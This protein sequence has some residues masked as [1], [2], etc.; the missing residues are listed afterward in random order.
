MSRRSLVVISAGMSQPSSTRLLA[1]QL[2]AAT[3]QRLSATGTSTDVTVIELRA[4]AH[5]ITNRLLA[6]FASPALQQALDAVAGADG[7]I[8][9]TP[10][11]SASYS[12]LFKSFFDVLDTDAVV[13]MPVLIAATGG[14][15]RHSLALEHALRPLFSYLRAAVMPTAVFAASSDWGS[16]RDADSSLA[17]R[18]DRAGGELSRAITSTAPR[19]SLDAYAGAPAFAELMGR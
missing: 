14:T 19:T 15:E 5:D 6:G 8:A 16:G 17:E 2:A 13:G 1:D 11:Y 4:L 7:L 9:V 3:E 12:G 18:I 10:L